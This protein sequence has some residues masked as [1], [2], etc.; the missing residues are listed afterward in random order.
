VIATMGL[1]KGVQLAKIGGGGGSRSPNNWLP[2]G[3]ASLGGGRTSPGGGRTSPGSLV[4]LRAR[5]F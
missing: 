3:R 5:E 1:A 2:D 4:T